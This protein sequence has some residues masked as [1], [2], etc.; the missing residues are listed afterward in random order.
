MVHA[1]KAS[2]GQKATTSAWQQVTST[3]LTLCSLISPTIMISPPCSVFISSFSDP[4]VRIR[5]NPDCGCSVWLVRA[6]VDCCLVPWLFFPFSRLTVS[7]DLDSRVLVADVAC[8]FRFPCIIANEAYEQLLGMKGRWKEGRKKGMMK[9]K[10]HR[11]GRAA[12][13]HK[14]VA[15]TVGKRSVRKLRHRRN[16]GVSV[17]LCM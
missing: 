1:K 11:Q 6:S 15:S 16:V 12:N 17:A 7:P 10:Q 5:C 13:F 3:S 9:K 8:R 14:P 2:T 4:P